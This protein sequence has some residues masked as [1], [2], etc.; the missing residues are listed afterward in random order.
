MLTAPRH[1]A[2]FTLTELLV[3]MAI[4]AVL[5]GLGMPSISGYIQTA[6]LNSSA[7]SYLAG[8]QAAR[9]TAIRQNLRSEF[10]L[11]DTPVETANLADALVASATGQNWVVRVTDP[12]RPAPAF[13]LVEARSATEGAA[14]VAQPPSVLITGISAPNAFAGIVPFN[15]FGS[16]ADASNYQFDLRNPQG[17]ACAPLGAMRCPRILVPAGGLARVCDPLVVAANDSRGC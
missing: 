5:V 1:A 10:V 15:G 13:L 7:Q 12:T 9:A 4:F 6:K 17:G 3:G 11:T 8:I 2:G 16:T 14:S